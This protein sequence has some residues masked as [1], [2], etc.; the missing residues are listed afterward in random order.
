MNRGAALA[1]HL[2]VIDVESAPFWAGTRQH[3]FLIRHC[4]ACGRSHFYPRHACPHCWSDNCEWRPSSGRGRIYS[5]T[6]IHHNEVLPFKEMLPYIVALIDLEEGVRVTA[7]IVEGTPE[8]MHVGMPVEVVY[9]HVTDAVTLPQFRPR[10]Q[11]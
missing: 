7:N 5:Y 2:P 6:V 1:H 9:E 4:N 10:A 3:K 8:V 11:T